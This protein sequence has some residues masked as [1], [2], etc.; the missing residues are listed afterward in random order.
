MVST[1][2]V[3]TR[4]I[5]VDDV[6][7]IGRV[8]F[9][10]PVVDVVDDAGG[11]VD[12]DAVSVDQPLERGARTDDVA[13]RLVGNAGQGD[14]VVDDDGRTVGL[15][16]VAGPFHLLNAPARVALRSADSDPLVQGVRLGL[17][18]AMWRSSRRWPASAK[19]KKSTAGCDFGNAGEDLRQIDLVSLTVVG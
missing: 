16:A 18:V 12:A 15:L 17:F 4:L 11:L 1:E 14:P 10:A 8:E 6:A 3:V 5:Q 7:G 13:V 9:E 19:A 2:T